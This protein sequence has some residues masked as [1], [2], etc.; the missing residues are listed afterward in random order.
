[1]LLIEDI[2]TNRVVVGIVFAFFIISIGS[3]VVMLLIIYNR[4]E[5]I[6]NDKRP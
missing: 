1:M 3:I 2:I 6:D 4:T 5:V